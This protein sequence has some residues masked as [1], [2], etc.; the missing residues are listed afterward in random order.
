MGKPAK[1]DRLPSRRILRSSR[2]RWM[3]WP[4]DLHELGSHWYGEGLAVGCTK[5]WGSRK[6]YSGERFATL[7]NPILHNP[8]DSKSELL[9]NANCHIH[10]SASSICHSNRL[11]SRNR[12]DLPICLESATDTQTLALGC[13]E[14]IL[15]SL[16]IPSDPTLIGDCL[17][18]N[19]ECGRV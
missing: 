14:N 2:P 17:R 18:I 19:S 7:L 5:Q 8:P 12:P 11:P 3:E 16:H 1:L 15:P 9:P 6:R 4:I 10:I 13:N